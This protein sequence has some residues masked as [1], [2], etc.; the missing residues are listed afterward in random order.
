MLWKDE[1]CRMMNGWKKHYEKKLLQNESYS[2]VLQ[3]MRCTG[4]GWVS[5]IK[6][7]LK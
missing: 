7:L 4:T 1:L 3:S 6:V 2:N 5:L